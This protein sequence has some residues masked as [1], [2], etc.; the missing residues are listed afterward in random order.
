MHTDP[1]NSP[2]TSDALAL[3]ANL[4]AL[5]VDPAACRARMAKLEKLLKQTRAASEKLAADREVHDEKVAKD[6]AELNDRRAR[7]N[8]KE[9]ELIG[10]EALAEK[11]LAREQSERRNRNR[12][13]ADN[14]SRTGG[15]MSSSNMSNKVLPSK[16]VARPATKMDES[17]A[18]TGP[19][20]STTF[21]PFYPNELVVGEPKPNSGE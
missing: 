7:L 16:K 9:L 5:A 20:K 21:K 17:K 1:L 3:V 14:H 15:S 19:G 2:G 4:I 10:R 18:I 6:R 12:P 13:L 8:A 11:T